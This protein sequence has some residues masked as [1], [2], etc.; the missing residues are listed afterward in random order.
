M[1]NK[2]GIAAY[3]ITKFARDDKKIESVLLESVKKLFD[4]CSSLTQ[5]DIDA[6]LVSTNNNSKYL[7][8]ILSEIA[9]IEPKIAHT[10][11]SL[12]N[13]GTNAIVSAYSYIA[14][15]LADVILVSGAERYDSPGQ[16]LEWDN[17]RGEFKHPIFWASIF[18]K[19]Y[20][21]QYNISEEDI[22]LVSVKNH[23]QAQKNPNALS[24]KEYTVKDIV[25]SKKITD[26]LRILDCSR[27][28][29]GGASIILASENAIGKFTENP[30]WIK[31]I[32][33][34]TASASFSK[35]ITFSAMESSAIAAHAALKMSDSRPEEIDVLEVH[36]AFSVCELMALEAIGITEK[37]KSANF[38]K[39]LLST[40]NQKV[41]PRGGL[42][43]AGHPLGATGIA[44]TIEVTQQLQGRADSRQIDHPKKGMIHNMSAASTSSTVLV[45]EN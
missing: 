36:D 21:S 23:R 11:E 4:S 7:G 16:I 24:E 10:V 25:N 26:D 20:K 29:T 12:C 9:G 27:P 39:D 43:G 38:V 15:G 31:G 6:V 41:N 17:S 44:Q 34:K 40:N 22:A 3:G 14:S 32:G 19:S 35:N 2:V 42:I 18:T 28:C 30:V 1:T 5:K 33:Q 8:S 45:L 37:G 13:S